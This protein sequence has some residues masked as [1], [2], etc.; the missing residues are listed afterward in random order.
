MTFYY[1]SRHYIASVLTLFAFPHPRIDRA[2]QLSAISLN[3]TY[4]P[5]HQPS[6]PSAHPSTHSSIRPS[7]HPFIHPLIHPPIHPSA[8]P[9]THSSIRSSIHPFIHPLI[10][11]PIHPSAIHPSTRP[12]SQPFARQ[13]SHP[14]TPHSPMLQQHYFQP[15]TSKDSQ[16][17]RALSP[18][19]QYHIEIITPILPKTN[20][21]ATLPKFSSQRLD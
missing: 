19:W 18:N 4:P 17:I 2:I 5:N 7:I 14:S 3:V 16:Y 6:H 21:S 15:L 1:D 13:F 20:H 11:P 12:P 8:H 10:H 9:S